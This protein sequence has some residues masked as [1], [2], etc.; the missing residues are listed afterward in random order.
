MQ[1]RY[2]V[3]MVGVRKIGDRVDGV[4]E[5]VD[6]GVDEIGSMKLVEDRP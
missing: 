4:E 5:R 2:L 3:A 1:V 6:L